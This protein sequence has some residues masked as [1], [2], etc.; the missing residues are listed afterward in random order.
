M[1]RT[2][3]SSE[4][5]A[6]AAGPPAVTRAPIAVSGVDGAVARVAVTVDLEHRWRGDLA[7]SLAAP[8][9]RA[10]CSPA[11]AAGRA[12]HFR[13]TVFD[14]VAPVAIDDAVPPFSGRFRPRG[15]L[16]DLHGC[17]ADGDWTLEVD[18]R[19]FH[20]A[21]AIRSWG[22]ELETAALQEPA[23][24]I[25]VRFQGG[26]TSAQQAAFT[27]AARAGRGSSPPTCRR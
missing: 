2:F 3:T 4:P 18:D 10:S 23:F 11:G 1:P 15:D 19:A 8:T 12:D 26:L 13:Q 9:A 5:V 17:H 22:L 27:T 21:G 20:D 6:I 25:D 14:A 7:L 16:A 24:V